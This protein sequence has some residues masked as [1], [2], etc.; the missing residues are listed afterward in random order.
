MRWCLFLG[1]VALSV[2]T[3]NVHQ[4]P[5]HQSDSLLNTTLFA[6]APLGEDTHQLDEVEATTNDEDH[7]LPFEDDDDEY[8]DD[9]SEFL[10]DPEALTDDGGE[11]EEEVVI[12]DAET[13]IVAEQLIQE[14]DHISNKLQDDEET[15]G[16][17]R[18]IS[19]AEVKKLER[20]LETAGLSP[21][22]PLLQNLMHQKHEAIPA[23][24]LGPN[25]AGMAGLSSLLGGTA[26]IGSG[27][28]ASASSQVSR[29]SPI[30][31]GS[32]T[33]KNVEEIKYELK[34]MLFGPENP[35][36]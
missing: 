35:V 22:S 20:L 18:A 31:P 16:T 10:P 3:S 14:L 15:V 21:N 9:E 33:K 26:P 19:S 13:R 17:S 24:V 4:D 32:M 25:M 7:S 28:L 5:N 23:S 27:S 6:E 12:L 34:H 11:E 2:S 29:S 30:V 1:L 8:L 36:S